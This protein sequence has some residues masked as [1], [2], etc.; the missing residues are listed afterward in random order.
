MKY[1]GWKVNGVHILI[2]RTKNLN[3]HSSKDNEN[4]L[5]IHH[6]HEFRCIK[7]KKQVHRENDDQ[8]KFTTGNFQ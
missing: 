2:S 7:V 1:I 8:G 5:I 6:S 3:E 4:I